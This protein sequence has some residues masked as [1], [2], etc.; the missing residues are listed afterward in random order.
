MTSVK[1][2][3][4][5]KALTGKSKIW[6]IVRKLLLV[7]KFFG[8]VCLNYMTSVKAGYLLKALTG[9]SKKQ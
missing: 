7:F 9:K 2:G 6:N 8:E 1:A 3:Y 5:L 4:L